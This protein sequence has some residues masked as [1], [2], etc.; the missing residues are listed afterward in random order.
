MPGAWS[1]LDR[2]PRFHAKQANRAEINL[3][4]VEL[5]SGYGDPPRLSIG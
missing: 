1:E 4:A 2:L 5:R 3:V